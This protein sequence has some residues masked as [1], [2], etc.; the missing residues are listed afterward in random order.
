MNLC[1]QQQMGWMMRKQRHWTLGLMAGCHKEERL[2]D[3]KY[4]HRPR[5]TPRPLTAGV[6]D[7]M[8]QT[9]N[10]SAEFIILK[11]T[12]RLCQD[13]QN[14]CLCFKPTTLATDVENMWYL[15]VASVFTIN[16]TWQSNR[17][18]WLT[19]KVTVA[20]SW[21]NYF[22]SRQIYSGVSGKWFL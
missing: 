12:P 5:V 21:L 2:K 10:S 7:V 13:H 22:T 19:V 17:F 1:I 3:C 20:K 4:K 11:V 14:N 15:Y 6:T 18:C 9:V 16:D 8:R